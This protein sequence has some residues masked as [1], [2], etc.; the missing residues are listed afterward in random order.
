MDKNDGEF[1][2]QFLARFNEIRFNQ[3]VGMNSDSFDFENGRI[4]FDMRDELIGNRSFNIMHGGIIAGVLDTVS[5]FVLIIN[6]AW[7]MT[8]SAT[9]KQEFRGGTI[10]L[11][12]DYLRPGK[13][14]RF[15]ASGNILRQGNKVAVVR[16]ELRNEQDELIAVGTGTY[17]IG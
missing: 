15:V 3:F 4:H 17:L 5:A 16:S 1:R 13:G 9:N 11:R 6:G 8:Y 10:D 14:K 2:K 12:V 7:R